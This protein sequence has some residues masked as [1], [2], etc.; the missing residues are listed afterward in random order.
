VLRARHHPLPILSHT[1]PLSSSPAPAASLHTTINLLAA[2][3]F[4]SG[5]G[6]RL[7]DGLIPRIASDFEVTTGRAGATVIAFVFAYGLMQLVSGPLGDHIG[8]ARMV[9]VAVFCCAAVGL[10]SA[11]AQEFD[12]LVALRVAWG[13]AAAGIVPLSMALVGDAVPFEERQPAL[14]RLLVGLLSGMMAGQLAGGIFADLEA[15][16][17]G[18]FVASAVGYLLVGLLLVSRLHSLPPEPP[19]HPGNFVDKLRLVTSQRWSWKVL[20]AAFVE[21][22]FLLGPL[23]YMPAILNQRFDTSLSVASGQLA[24]YA[25]GGLLYALTA[26]RIVSRWGQVRMVRWGG[27]VMGAG[28]LAW[29]GSSWAWTAAPVALAIGFGTYLFHN[30]LQTHATQMAPAARGTATSMFAFAFF[31]GQAVGTW[32]AGLAFDTVGAWGVLLPPV[33]ALPLVSWVFAAAL[34]RRRAM[35]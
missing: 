35:A 14:A 5:V 12:S 28:Y 10:L 3:A 17:R 4:F 6:L 15:G 22:M 13:M 16:W 20:G 34:R 18:A 19:S 30:T 21:G 24:L 26:R 11:A 31:M 2:A 9:G 32:L 33:V 1:R 7:C 25:V 29:W 8:K 27:L 23:T